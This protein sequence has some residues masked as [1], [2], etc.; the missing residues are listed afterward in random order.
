[1]TDFEKGA[2]NAGR[3]VFTQSNRDLSEMTCRNLS[4]VLKS[5]EH[6]MLF[7]NIYVIEITEWSLVNDRN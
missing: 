4:T 1:M 5:V 3:S 7:Q 6:L 2:M